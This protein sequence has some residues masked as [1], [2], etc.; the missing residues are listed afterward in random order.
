MITRAFENAFRLKNKREWSYIYV[1]LDLHSTLLKPNY[2]AGT[3]PT[4][5]Y[6]GALE[7][8]KT[9]N[10]AEDM[11][12]IMYTCSHPHEIEEYV[13]LFAEKG[14]VFD[15]IN[16]NP[17]VKTTL[18]GYGCYDKKPYFNVL[19][20]DKAGFDAEEDWAVVNA[21]LRDRYKRACPENWF[22]GMI[23]NFSRMPQFKDNMHVRS[24]SDIDVEMW[25]KE[26]PEADFHNGSLTKEEF[27]VRI[28]EAGAKGMLI[29]DPWKPLMD[30]IG[31]TQT[32][33]GK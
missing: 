26:W 5:F 28:K 18:D 6:D 9:M 8:L 15:Y 1:F 29:G 2:T 21:Y 25:N 12:I 7:G 17:E 10:E 32:D 13:K 24:I 19:F 4:E 22:K 27:V 14:I 23:Q 11:R 16:E 33:L 3:I 20:E 31:Q 30:K